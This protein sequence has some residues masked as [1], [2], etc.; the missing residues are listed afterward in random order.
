MNDKPFHI[1]IEIKS[2]YGKYLY[3]PRNATAFTL[4]D[5][6]GTE[7]L[8]QRTLELAKRMG[9]SIEFNHQIPP[10]ISAL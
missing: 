4:A 7:T 6:A 5:I 9:F 8:T 10:E 1:Q 3:Y 2:V